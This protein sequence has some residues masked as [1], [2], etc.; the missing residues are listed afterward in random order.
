[1]RRSVLRG[2]VRRLSLAGLLVIG[3]CAAGEPARPEAS[4][5]PEAA[6]PA[7]APSAAPLSGR[8]LA[9]DLIAMVD[10]R[11]AR[12][13]LPQD[14]FVLDE[15]AAADDGQIR[16]YGAA[17]IVGRA[18]GHVYLATAE[19]VVYLASAEQGNQPPPKLEVRF[20]FF[21]ER[22]FQAEALRRDQELDLAV[23][24]VAETAELA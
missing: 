14:D 7:E 21:P 20:R 10:L 3:G 19:H 17:I 12:P 13:E 6:P 2:A 5:A 8:E 11:A 1:V 24:R 15:A 9:F 16:Q 22:R 18:D 4:I 23:L